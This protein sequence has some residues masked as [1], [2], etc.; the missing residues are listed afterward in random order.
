MKKNEENMLD[1][2]GDWELKKRGLQTARNFNLLLNRIN[3]LTKERDSKLKSIENQM[4]RHRE[5][6]VKKVENDM[7]RKQVSAMKLFS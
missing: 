4:E 7:Q 5:F 1:T 3:V 6:I 2:R